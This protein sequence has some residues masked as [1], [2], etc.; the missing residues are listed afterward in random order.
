MGPFDSAGFAGG[1]TPASSA[2]FSAASA[3]GSGVSSAAGSAASGT[4]GF[5]THFPLFERAA[6]A[7]VLEDGSTVIVAPTAAGKSFVGR[8]VIRRA[9]GIFPLADF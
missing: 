5:A 9:L 7:G 8:E 2:G 3:A 4:P 1:S 6:R